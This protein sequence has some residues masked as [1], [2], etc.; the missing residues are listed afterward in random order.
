MKKIILLLILC[1]RVACALH[2]QGVAPMGAP[3]TKSL[4]RGLLTADSGL[5][6][7]TSFNISHKF[8]ST[9]GLAVVGGLFYYHDGS[10]WINV[11][12]GGSSADSLYYVTIYRWDTA[13]LNNY[14]TIWALK[15][16]IDS[17]DAEL[18]N[19]I[20]SIP[21]NTNIMNADLTADANHTQ[22]FAT[23]GQIWNNMSYMRVTDGSNNT[24]IDLNSNGDGV[25]YFGN[26]SY[27]VEVDRN[28]TLIRFRS[29]FIYSGGVLD[30]VNHVIAGVATPV[31]G[32]DAT[33]KTYVDG[34]ASGKLNISDSTIY[35]SKYDADTSRMAQWGQIRLKLNASD[36]SLYQTKYRSDTMRSDL[37]PVINGKLN[38]SD[39]SIYQSKYRS[40]TARNNLWPAING[41]QSTTLS[42]GQIWVG[43]TGNVAT[44]TPMGGDVTISSTGVT[45]LTASGV[46]AS[47]YGSATS[48]PIFT[49]DAKGRITLASN[50]G[51]TTATIITTTNFTT[52][53]TLAATDSRPIRV[54]ITAQAGSL[55]L[56]APTGLSDGQQVEFVMKATGSNQ[57]LSPNSVFKPMTDNAG[58]TTTAVP[59][60][61]LTAVSTSML[62]EYNSSSGFLNMKGLVYNVD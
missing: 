20:G 39:S 60:T 29:P 41:K 38:A 49:V 51:I 23:F 17:N 62:F 43:S 22:D 10:M 27:G 18:W 56:N 47:T 4:A 52:S 25:S 55:T 58:T 44:G 14:N 45:T 54:R 40:D 19:A 21:P 36:S 13:K 12:S 53:Y 59:T 42:N 30:M 11:T 15:A 33:N 61:I 37:W 26:G 34:V 16:Y 7:P 1:M 8:D 3:T 50:A 2:A 57:T 24:L 46:T 5:V 32:Q 9:G 6:A 28:N 48:I 31:S 35:E